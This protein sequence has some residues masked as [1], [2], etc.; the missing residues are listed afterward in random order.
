[1][2]DTAASGAYQATKDAVGSAAERARAAAP[3]VY[4]A[5]ARGTQYVTGTASDHPIV[6]LLATAGVAYL[7]GR[8]GRGSGDDGTDWQGRAESL[9]QQLSTLASSLPDAA[10]TVAQRGRAAPDYAGQAASDAGD[11][12]TRGANRVGAYLRQN[13]DSAG[14]YVRMG[15]S[16]AGEYLR[17]NAGG[18]GSYV[19]QGVREYPASTLMGVMAAGALLGYLIRGRS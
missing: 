5:A 6:A 17:Q 19:A 8:L 1:M 11:Y 4:D 13:A 18:A 2:S 10:T 14:D 12:A 15:A 9:R 16:R 3:S 7:L